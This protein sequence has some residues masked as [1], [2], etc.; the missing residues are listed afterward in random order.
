MPGERRIPRSLRIRQRAL[1]LLFGGIAHDCLNAQAI[2][3]ERNGL[4]PL[5]ELLKNGPDS[6]KEAVGVRIRLP[7]KH[8]APT[9]INFAAK[10]KLSNA[11]VL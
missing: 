8:F 7:K 3:S 9:W 4:T 1:E 2:I 10:V 6:A 5:V 11:Y